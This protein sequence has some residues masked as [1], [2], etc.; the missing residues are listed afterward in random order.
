MGVYRTQSPRAR[1]TRVTRY[2][3]TAA[4]GLLGNFGQFGAT[5]FH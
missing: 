2:I 3:L 5:V 1:G 4:P